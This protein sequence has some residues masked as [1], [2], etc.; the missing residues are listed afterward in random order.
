MGL[1]IMRTLARLIPDRRVDLMCSEF[2]GRK[3][4][5]RT[6]LD[7]PLGNTLAFGKSLE[8]E[9]VTLANQFLTKSSIVIDVGCR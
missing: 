1:R 3:L 4:V 5:Y 8:P 2:D 7:S 6:T 9:I